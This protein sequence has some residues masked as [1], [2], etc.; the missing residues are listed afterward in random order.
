MSLR[1]ICAGFVLAISVVLA[2]HCLWAQ[3]GIEGALSRANLSSPLNRGNP[4]GRTLAV[5]DFDNDH[6]LDGAV[7]VDS[8]QL[9]GRKTFRIRLY[10]SGSGNSELIFESAETALA[11]RTLDVNEDGATDVVIERP[12]SHQRLYVWLNDG[13]GDFRGGPIEDSRHRANPT[14]DQFDE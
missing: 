9:H 2:A 12:L 6:K 1:S 13:H 4:L 3:D 8:G 5:A 10:L 7:L 11:I 14:G